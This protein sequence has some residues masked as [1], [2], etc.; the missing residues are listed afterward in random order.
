ME[1]WQFLQKKTGMTIAK[2]WMMMVTC[3][4]VF[5]LGAGIFGAL[6][7]L[8]NKNIEQVINDW[9]F[10]LLIL[11]LLISSL[12][13]FFINKKQ[14]PAFQRVSP[15]VYVISLVIA[16]A[17]AYIHPIVVDFLPFNEVESKNI[18]NLG[19]SFILGAISALMF[20]TL[21]IGVIGHGLLTNYLFKQVIFTVAAV[22]IVMVVPQAVIG[23]FIQTL[24]M[25]Y[26]YYRTAAFQLPLL[27]TL[28]F[29]VLEDIF[30][31]KINHDVPTKNYIRLYLIGN[32]SVYYMGLLIAIISIL[33]GL[34]LIKKHTLE[35]IWQKNDS[36]RNIEFL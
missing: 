28:S 13:G 6:A 18:Q 3:I 10:G 35:I 9:V 20:T 27:M 21:Q 17:W 32:E 1:D 24:I 2:A 31:Y 36:E 16:F 7:A 23:L 25:F 4:I 22:S 33:G 19:P 26:I 8:Q 34:Y 29:S 14:L 15:I 30:K 12:I 11:I 5:F